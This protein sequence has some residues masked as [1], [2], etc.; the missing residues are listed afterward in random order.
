M[1]FKGLRR[2]FSPP[3]EPNLPE[4]DK[5]KKKK[6]GRP[7]TSEE[8]LS[9]SN[10]LNPPANQDTCLGVQIG[11]G[12]KNIDV[13]S[14]PGQQVTSL[15]SGG[16]TLRWNGTIGLPLHTLGRRQPRLQFPLKISLTKVQRVVLPMVRFSF[17]NTPGGHNISLPGLAVEEG[18]DTPVPALAGNKKTTAVARG[19][20]ANLRKNLQN[21]K[22]S[23]QRVSIPSLPRTG[24]GRT[25]IGREAN[26]DSHKGPPI[27][28]SNSRCSSCWTACWPYPALILSCLCRRL[29]A[30]TAHAVGNFLHWRR[31]YP[32]WDQAFSISCRRLEALQRMNS[33]VIPL[34]CGFAWLKPWLYAAQTTSKKRIAG[35]QRWHLA[36]TKSAVFRPTP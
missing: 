1:G 11:P 27:S 8:S 12:R 28:G 16:T 25:R 24:F 31:V 33:P 32:P 4:E 2:C 18:D 5:K 21:S 30:K 15:H 34:A 14:P 10:T 3:G 35:P 19:R 26:V 23:P 22:S 17:M 20:H 9:R 29:L 13:I 6:I 36:P 7:S